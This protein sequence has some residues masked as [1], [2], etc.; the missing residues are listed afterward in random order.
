MFAGWAWGFL[1]AIA[2]AVVNRIVDFSAQ[3]CNSVAWWQVRDADR[4]CHGHLLLVQ[5]C[6]LAG[7]VLSLL[8]LIILGFDSPFAYLLW[9]MGG[10]FVIVTVTPIFT[11]ELPISLRNK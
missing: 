3:Y 7:A 1:L 2:N 5:I 6:T 9:T 11:W 4:V 8:I 10:V